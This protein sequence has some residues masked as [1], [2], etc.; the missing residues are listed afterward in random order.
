MNLIEKYWFRVKT[1][2]AIED[3]GV[4]KD[5]VI[6]KYKNVYIQLLINEDNE[7]ASLG[8]SDNPTMFNIPVREWWTA[9]PPNRKQHESSLKP[10]ATQEEVHKRRS[11]I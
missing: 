5:E 2:M 8:W 1:G 7:I 9:N 4:I 3:L 6:I 11:E 10:D